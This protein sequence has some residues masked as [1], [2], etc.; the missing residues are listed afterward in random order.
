MTKNLNP[1]FFFYAL[2]ILVLLLAIP[3]YSQSLENSYKE[4]AGKFN[5]IDGYVSNTSN[6]S[7][8]FYGASGF[9][10]YTNLHLA[11]VIKYI[12]LQFN[13]SV[14]KTPYRDKVDFSGVSLSF[15]NRDLESL[16]EKRSKKAAEQIK[17]S[18]ALKNNFSDSLK[19]FDEILSI[20]SDPQFQKDHSQLNQRV[21]YLENLVKNNPRADTSLI[22]YNNAKDSL[23][24]YDEVY[25]KYYAALNSR[26]KQLAIENYADSI[27]GSSGNIADRDLVLKN[28]ELTKLSPA[29]KILRNFNHIDIGLINV[30]DSRLT[31]SNFNISG[32]R[33]EYNNNKIFLSFLTGKK[34]VP[35]YYPAPSYYF[36]DNSRDKINLTQFKIGMGNREGTH[37]H[38]SLSRFSERNIFR[39]DWQRIGKPETSGTIVGIESYQKISKQ[40]DA[41]FEGAHNL[42]TDAIAE[43]PSI[44]NNSAFK[45]E[46]KYYFFSSGTILSSEYFY[47]GSE[48]HS[49]GNLY[50]NKGFQTIQTQVT[51]PFLRNKLNVTMGYSYSNSIKT[52]EPVKFLNTKIE[53]KIKYKLSQNLQIN[54]R[55]QNN[56]YKSYF[57][58]IESMGRQTFISNLHFIDAAYS[59]SFSEKV[60]Y[61]SV[62]L[63]YY[64][65]KNVSEF[66]SS[67]SDNYAINLMNSFKFNVKNSAALNFDFSRNNSMETL[68][69]N[70]TVRGTYTRQLSKK[71]EAEGGIEKSIVSSLSEYWGALFNVSLNISQK[72]SSGLSLN[73]R[74]NQS[75]AEKITYYNYSGQTFLKFIF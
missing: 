51:R 59:L 68:I 6:Y 44:V 21:Y 64:Q 56:T 37:T 39:D 9:F 5:L 10:N 14:V 20:I 74:I 1:A 36:S 43:H 28:D 48:Y 40:L 61:S 22:A 12:P 46:V 47:C 63:G 49:P 16:I 55:Y 62:G 3:S 42:V 7:Q 58:G 71:C 25:N 13:L 8:S 19:N 2:F 31:V 35:G 54:Y 41:R 66:Y 69:D 65:N 33:T 60:L 29:E 17:D 75:S 23:D 26:K 4:P 27:T 50:M 67:T 72:I 18:L 38:L 45:T 11:P 53:G 70:I 32:F 57:Q 30:N 34:H 73:W 24:T 52:S 15:S